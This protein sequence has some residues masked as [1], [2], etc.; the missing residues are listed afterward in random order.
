MVTWESASLR[1]SV[2]GPNVI[3]IVRREF[4]E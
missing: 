1:P 4:D 2:N 3:V